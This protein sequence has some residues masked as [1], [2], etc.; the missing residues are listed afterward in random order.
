MASALQTLCGQA[1]GA[2]KYHML[3]I[4]MQ[5]AWI[6]LFLIAVLTLPIFLFAS[7]ILRLMGQ[8]A[9]VAEL[10]GVVARW[11]VPL[12][13]GLVFLFPLQRFLQ[14]QLKNA[15]LAYVSLAVLALHVLATYACVV[16]LGFGVVGTAVALSA[17]WWLLFVGLIAY[18][19]CGGCPLTWTGLSVEAFSD[20]WEFTKLS[21]ASGVMI[22]YDQVL[23]LSLIF[24]FSIIER[25]RR[26]DL[27]RIFYGVRCE[28]IDKKIVSQ[29]YCF[30]IHKK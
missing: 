5:R 18:T 29:H 10:T 23:L 16:W 26:F 17:S 30:G 12:H 15:V 25:S 1:F 4:Y 21:A 3:G 20:L 9:A 11:V 8:A 7:P 19:V 13:F 24:F 27:L 14:C 2:K 28:I 6:V 22:W